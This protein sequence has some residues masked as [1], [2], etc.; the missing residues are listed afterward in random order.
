M[1]KRKCLTEKKLVTMENVKYELNARGSPCARGKCP[2]CGRNMYTILKATE[3]PAE[4]KAKIK[5]RGG[6][7]HKSRKSR[8]SRN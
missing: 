6:A 8:K 7:S 1:I 5:A 4:L 3:V 2:S